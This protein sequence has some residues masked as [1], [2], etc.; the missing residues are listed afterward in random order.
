MK[1]LLLYL[2]QEQDSTF[3]THAELELPDSVTICSLK[4]APTAVRTYIF[5]RHLTS[6]E[7][8]DDKAS[9]ETFF[10]VDVWFIL[11]VFFWETLQALWRHSDSESAVLDGQPCT[12][13]S[14]L[15]WEGSTLSGMTRK[16]SFFV[17]ILC[18]PSFFHRYRHDGSE[19]LTDDI[20]FAA[21]DGIH[22]VDFI[23]QVKVS[24]LHIAEGNCLCWT[25]QSLPSESLCIP[26]ETGR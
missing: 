2:C 20:L 17:W 5:A 23:L 26:L 15:Y 10:P 3:H 7:N 16:R 6:S 22:F 1:I 21:T 14:F 4:M 25:V 24:V 13:I 12:G 19:S 11:G 8:T 9:G 18:S